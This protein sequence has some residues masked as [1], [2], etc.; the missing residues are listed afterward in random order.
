MVLALQYYSPTITT[1]VKRVNDS[2]ADR[3]TGW[4]LHVAGGHD[5]SKCSF[6]D[7]MHDQRIIQIEHHQTS[8]NQG[9]NHND[10]YAIMGRDDAGQGRP[11]PAMQQCAK[12]KS[13]MH[14]KET[15]PSQKT[16]S[17]PQCFPCKCDNK[18]LDSYF[19]PQY[20]IKSPILTCANLGFS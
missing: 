19:F 7:T 5:P 12:I 10:C 15:Y 6:F 8:S 18:L 11:S 13:C 17:H 3:C 16:C 2:A 1:Y 9:H 20:Q 4:R 14:A